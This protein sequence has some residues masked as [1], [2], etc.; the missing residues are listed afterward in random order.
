[1]RPVRISTCVTTSRLPSAPRRARWLYE[2]VLAQ[3]EQPVGGQHPSRPL[4]NRLE[5]G[6][7]QKAG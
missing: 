2:R 1:M 3:W 7:G 6:R 5:T 4:K